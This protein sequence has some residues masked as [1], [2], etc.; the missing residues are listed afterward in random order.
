MP[1]GASRHGRDLVAMTVRHVLLQMGSAR[2]NPFRKN[3][4]L[5]I[6]DARRCS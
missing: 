5:H 3:A 6:D 2:P 1:A 4:A